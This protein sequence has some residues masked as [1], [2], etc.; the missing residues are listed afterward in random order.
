MAVDFGGIKDKQCR[1]CRGTGRSEA[2][3]F[4]M[5]HACIYCEGKGRIPITRPRPLKPIC[6]ICKTDDCM[7][8]VED[9][10]MW[11]GSEHLKQCAACEGTGKVSDL[12]PTR[13]RKILNDLVIFALEHGGTLRSH[14]QFHQM[15]S[16]LD[17]EI[18]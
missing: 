2:G 11:L 16:D 13:A 10:Q 7:L 4:S 1:A 8:W 14:R 17:Q 6:E 12:V 15:I 3:C 9:M 5:S 18:K